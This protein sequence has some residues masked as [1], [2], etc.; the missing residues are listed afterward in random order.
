MDYVS[1]FEMSINYISLSS[2]NEFSEL[3]LIE[4]ILVKK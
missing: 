1:S 4:E 3:N 2:V